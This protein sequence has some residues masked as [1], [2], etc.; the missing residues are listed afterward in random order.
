[1]V[2]LY[3]HRYLQ[4]CSKEVCQKHCKVLNKFLIVISAIIVDGGDI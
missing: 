2:I 3:V 1:M 4:V